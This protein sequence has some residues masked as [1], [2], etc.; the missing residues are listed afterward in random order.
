[1]DGGD[2]LNTGMSDRAD[3][4]EM[5]GGDGRE[6]REDV[7][8]APYRRGEDNEERGNVADESEPVEE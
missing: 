1:V 3:N 6:A 7:E 4:T 5:T 8:E 2:G